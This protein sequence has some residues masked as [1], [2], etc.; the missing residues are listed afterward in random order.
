MIGWSAIRPRTSRNQANGSGEASGTLIQAR[1]ALK[2]KKKLFILE[3]NFQNPALSSWTARATVWPTIRLAVAGAAEIVKVLVG[4]MV[5]ADAVTAVFPELVTLAVEA[6][7]QPN[8]H[9]PLE[10]PR[11]FTIS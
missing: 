5:N 1:H 6:H 9:R 4:L 11:N 7:S 3:N 8:A 2:Q 10:R